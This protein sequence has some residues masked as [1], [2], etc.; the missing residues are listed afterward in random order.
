MTATFTLT[1]ADFARLQKMV[2]RRFPRGVGARFWQLVL[3]ALV[4]L[5]IGITGATYARVMKDVPEV[6]RPLELLA[7]LL[8]ITLVV[9][10]AMPYASQ[11]LMRKHMLAPN[12]AFLSPQ[13]VTLSP[14]SITV[15]SAR[16]ITIVPWS[17]VLAR[18]Q[19]DTNHYLFIDAMQALV[20]PRSAMALA[21]TDFE[22]Y[23]RH[24]K[25]AA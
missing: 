2:A 25:G 15:K 22:K 21:A 14:D 5:C 13:T 10:V 16:A 19:D 24:L 6:H 4:W 20:I 1:H 23:T 18:D 3:R 17:G 11:L 7:Y 9:I 8:A 12:G